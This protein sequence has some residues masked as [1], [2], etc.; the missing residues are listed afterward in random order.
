MH[1]EVIRQ[2]WL[3]NRSISFTDVELSPTAPLLA[4]PD[5]AYPYRVNYDYANW[6]M[7]TKLVSEMDNEEEEKRRFQLH[8]NHNEIPLKS[9]MQLIVDGEFFLS[10]SGLPHLYIYLLR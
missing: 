10:Q 5:W 6:K 9:R 3:K 4:N 7:L 8:D 2:F 1:F